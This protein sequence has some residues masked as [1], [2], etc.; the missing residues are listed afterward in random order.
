MTPGHTP[1][2]PGQP[3]AG[4]GQEPHPLP[5]LG[6]DAGKASPGQANSLP[7]AMNGMYLHPLPCHNT[8]ATTP[9]Q[10]I[11]TLYSAR[12]RPTKKPVYGPPQIPPPFPVCSTPVAP[13][14]QY[15]TH[16]N[17]VQTRHCAA[18]IPLIPS[19][20]ADPS[21][22]GHQSRRQYPPFRVSILPD[23]PRFRPVPYPI[24]EKYARAQTIT[25]VY[26][27]LLFQMH[28]AD[29]LA[30]TQSEGEYRPFSG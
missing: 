28:C 24:Q 14:P 13:Q 11:F 8:S 16:R 19:A 29:T 18:C 12:N 2:A 30:A 3:K 26:F 10:S 4:H 1:P 7:Q 9:P 5:I 23:H 6:A 25:I 21:V 15:N 17:G 20:C 22:A 27:M